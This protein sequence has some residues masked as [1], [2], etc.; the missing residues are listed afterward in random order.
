MA[1]HQG[2]HTSTLPSH[3]GIVGVVT[4]MLP[5]RRSSKSTL[6][7][8]HKLDKKIRTN[9]NNKQDIIPILSADGR[10]IINPGWE[11]N[12]RNPPKKQFSLKHKHK[13]GYVTYAAL[14]HE[15]SSIWDVKIK[16]PQEIKSTRANRYAFLVLLVG[17]IKN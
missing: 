3:H 2:A 1:T 13:C 12:P 14:A 8:E 17:K 10:C 16:M 5:T 15:Y 11:Y 4:H 6:P 7:S 9:T